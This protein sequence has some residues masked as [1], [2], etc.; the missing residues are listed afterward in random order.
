MNFISWVILAVIIVCF[1][2]AVR[3]TRKHGSCE[4]CG[5]NCAVHTAS[6]GCSAGCAGCSG[7]CDVTTMPMTKKE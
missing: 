6:G 7:S 1:V 5:G 2:L 3:Y 4:A